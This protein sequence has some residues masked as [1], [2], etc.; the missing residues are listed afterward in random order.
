MKRAL[1]KLPLYNTAKY[2]YYGFGRYHRHLRNLLKPTARILL[3]HRIARSK[4]DP[5][6]LCVDPQNFHAQIKFLKENYRIIPLVKLAQDIR[7]GRIEKSTIVITFDDGYAD[8]L[9]NALPILEEFKVSAT[10]FLMAGYM[11]QPAFAKASA[12]ENKSFYWDENT[13]PEDQGQ[14]IITD[15]AKLLSN[16]H[17]IE[18]G[19]HTLTHPKLVNL[20]ENE[21]FN[22]I[23]GSKKALEELLKVPISGFAYPFGG[24]NSFDK[25]TVELV[26]K[27]GFEYACANIHERATNRSNIYALPRFVVRNW[28]LNEFQQRLKGFI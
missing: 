19:A 20:D 10:I 3:Y 16:S 4:N 11:A 15:E 14:P 26:K 17:L 27:T 23:L 1:K 5:Y 7:K 13:P 28:N 2:V 9:Y 24:K 12:G 6:L 21:Q 25:T 8:N 18:I 22:E